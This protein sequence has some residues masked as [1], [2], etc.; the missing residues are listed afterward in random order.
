[1]SEVKNCRA[2]A[3]L[4]LFLRI[5]GK[6]ED[7]YHLMDMVNVETTFYDELQIMID[8]RRSNH[9]YIETSQN[10]NCSLRKNLIY[11]AWKWY[12]KTTGK[13]VHTR[14][15][16]KKRI[17][18]GA[19]LGGG[20]SDAAIFLL[21][22]N[23]IYKC[24]SREELI[25]KSV[26]VGADVPYFLHG[27]LCRVTGIGEIVEPLPENDELKELKGI[28]CFPGKHID[29]KD[30]YEK[31]DENNEYFLY[32]NENRTVLPPE[33]SLYHPAIEIYPL[34]ERLMEEIQD[35]NPAYCGMT[36][37]GSSCFGIYTENEQRKMKDLFKKKGYRTWE[38]N[39]IQRKRKI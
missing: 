34:I 4:N 20:S 14:V 26:E 35:T 12:T 30:V 8:K 11:K 21:E 10:F 3:K 2:Y 29:T 6:R 15:Y 25:S 31:F 5:T 32:P 27:G 9:C 7:G 39:F 16:L 33:N 24:F 37:S 19:G 23:D 28:I 1:M 17:P 36:G 22:I 38:V 18:V 13:S